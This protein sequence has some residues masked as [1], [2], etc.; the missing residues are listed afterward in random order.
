MHVRVIVVRWR[1]RAHGL[2]QIGPLSVG[3]HQ[4]A[5]LAPAC[6][7]YTLHGL[8]S[9]LVARLATRGTAPLTARRAHNLPLVRLARLPML[10]VL[11]LQICL[12][13]GVI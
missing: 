5:D 12:A 7:P 3:A 10:L 13:C 1:D 8:P 4:E 6:A 9:A 2:A 11:P